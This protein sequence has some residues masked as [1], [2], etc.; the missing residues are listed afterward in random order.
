MSQVTHLNTVGSLLSCFLLE[1]LPGLASCVCPA[2]EPWKAPVLRI[3]MSGP[4]PMDRRDAGRPLA[5][6][7]PSVERWRR[8]PEISVVVP[9]GVVI[10]P[11]EL[12]SVLSQCRA[13]YCSLS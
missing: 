4:W 1:A 11:T 9:Q 5:R 7:E 12:S 10:E 2:V 13:Y 8:Y 3:P 6:G